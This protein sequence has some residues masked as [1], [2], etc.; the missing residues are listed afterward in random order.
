MHKRQ[1]ADTQTTNT[2]ATDAI[3]ALHLGAPLTLATPSLCVGIVDGALVCILH[4]I[5][6]RLGIEQ[7]RS[8]Q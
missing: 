8:E 6:V 2:E 3:K 4:V 7:I 1:Y 5:A